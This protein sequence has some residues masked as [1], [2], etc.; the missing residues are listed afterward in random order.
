MCGYLSL[1]SVYWIFKLI[2]K[3]ED[4]RYGDFKLF[5]AFEA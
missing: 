4:I 5:T 1:W 2:T 3:K